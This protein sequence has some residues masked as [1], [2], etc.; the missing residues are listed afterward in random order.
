MDGNVRHRVRRGARCRKPAG[1]DGARVAIARAIGLRYETWLRSHATLACTVVALGLWHASSIGRPASHAS[2]RL[3]LTAYALL[4]LLLLL[5]RRVVRPLQLSRR[6]WSVASNAD[7]GGDTRLLT[8]KPVGHGGLAFAPG[9]FVWLLTGRHALVAQQHPI[10]IASSAEASADRGLEFAIKALEDRS[11]E[12]VPFPRSDARHSPRRLPCR[13]QRPCP[14]DPAAASRH[15]Q[16]G[17][18]LANRGGVGG[19]G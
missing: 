14:A 11:G 5:W 10:T 13:C 7:I 3:T 18:G 17:R 4:A 19:A 15:S 9:Q 1:P 2:V 12:T 16:P 6:P 8:V